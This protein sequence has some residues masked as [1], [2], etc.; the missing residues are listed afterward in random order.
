MRYFPVQ[1]SS[2]KNLQ[3]VLHLSEFIN[4]ADSIIN[5]SIA[6]CLTNLGSRISR[7]LSVIYANTVANLQES[8]A[9][10]HV[11]GSDVQVHGSTLKLTT[12]QIQQLHI[13][14]FLVGRNSSSVH[15]NDIGIDV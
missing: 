1:A 3:L 6:N 15:T 5:N 12:G 11:L 13:A 7:A 4:K 10:S 2:A 9:V 8:T 14:N